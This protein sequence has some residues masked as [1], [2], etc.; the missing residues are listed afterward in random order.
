ML[1]GGRLMAAIALL[2]L[3]PLPEHGTSLGVLLPALA[4]IGIGNV[5]S[6]VA[7]SAG[8]TD[9][10]EQGELGRASGVLYSAQQVGAALG[11]SV[12]I[13]LADTRT[14]LLAQSGMDPSTALVDGFRYA[15]G[16]AALISF[17][18]AIVALAEPAKARESGDAKP[19]A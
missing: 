8:A 2:I 9:G 19:G 4:L 16:G 5:C 6:F 10:V 18:A 11:I 1:V 17:V 3:T 13:A 15:L 7:S 12:L 14:R